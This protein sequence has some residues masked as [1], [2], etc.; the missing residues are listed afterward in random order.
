MYGNTVT[1]MD[2]I[3]RTCKYNLPCFFLTVKTTVG[4]GQVVATIIPEFESEEMILQGLKIVKTLNPTWNPSFF[5][6]DKSEVKLNAIAQIY[7]K[8]VH[9]LYD[10]H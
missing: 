5:M 8:A 2:A 6:M 4:I 10:F 3:Y 1:L 9:L 7:P